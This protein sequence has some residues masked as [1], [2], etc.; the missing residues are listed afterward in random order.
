MSENN[1]PKAH[2]KSY[3]KR[4]LSG[5]RP[6]GPL[7]VGH[8]LGVLENWVALQDE[9]E[10][11]YFVADWHALSTRYDHPEDLGRFSVEIVRDWLASG[12][13]PERS[14]LFLQSDILAHSELFVLLSM[15]TPISWLERVPSYKDMKAQLQGADID[16]YGF[17]GYP[18][19]QAADIIIHQA[20]GV[21]V[22]D[23][24]LPHVEFTREV[25]R[26][27]HHQYGVDIFPEPKPLLSPACR[28]PGTDGRKMSKSFNNVLELSDSAEQTVKKV[29][30][31]KT[32]PAR[33][34]LTDPGD[35]E[36][37]PV[38]EYHKVVTPEA[39]REEIIA[40]C[41]SAA[42][43]CVDCKLRMTAHLNLRLAPMREKRAT[44]SD[45]QVRAVL[46]DH[47]Q[48]ALASAETTMAEVRKAVGVVG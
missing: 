18:L 40:G 1:K 44:I 45:D 26:R 13:D 17:L 24:Q 10:C 28:L 43:G 16:T 12:I 25:V 14:T 7:H 15:I 34:R 29:K 47:R 46:A 9:W 6:T 23:D 19:L 20:T 35:P 48:K 3:P 36:K 27:F 2:K 30:R 31:M 8:Y 41:K 11:Y 21:P 37:C 33:I 42:F 39:E 22:G 4:V 38:F 5:M 32:D